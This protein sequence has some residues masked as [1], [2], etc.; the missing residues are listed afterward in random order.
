[1][2]SLK[3]ISLA[4]TE[5]AVGLRNDGY[6]AQQKPSGDELAQRFLIAAEVLDGIARALNKPSASAR[7]HNA[8]SS[9]PAPKI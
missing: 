6:A 2:K 3:T 5:E 7:R 9:Q 8:D 4:L 1:M